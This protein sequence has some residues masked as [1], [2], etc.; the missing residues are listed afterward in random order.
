MKKR[1]SISKIILRSIGVFFLIIAYLLVFLM[2]TVTA[3]FRGPSDTMKNL[4]VSSLMETSAMK[5]IP[6]AYFTDEEIDEI[7]HGN[8]DKYE[9]YIASLSDVE[10]KIP[11]KD[12]MNTEESG[13][14]ITV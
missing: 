14:G 13:T 8:T 4:L 1:L 12:D 9:E 10:I 7:T 3:V 2:C 6:R 5:F 11:Q